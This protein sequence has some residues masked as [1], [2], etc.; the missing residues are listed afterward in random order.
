MKRMNLKR[1]TVPAIIAICGLGLLV[2]EA[3][4]GQAKP[5]Q[6]RPKPVQ[7][8]KD[9]G[10]IFSL[11]LGGGLGFFLDGGG[12]LENMRLARTSYYQD[13]KQDPGYTEAWTNWKKLSQ[14]PNYDVDLIF[15]LT[16]N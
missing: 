13:L 15:H 14:A 6:A 2:I 10:P 7:K 9:Y 12:D 5:V 3:D 4:A 1:Y 8:V 16:E 11:K